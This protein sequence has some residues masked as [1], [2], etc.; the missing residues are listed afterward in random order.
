[1]WEYYQSQRPGQVQVLGPDIFNGTASQL[2]GFRVQ[3]GATYPLLL[4]GGTGAGDEDL[5]SPTTYGQVDNYV[6][7]NKQGVIRYHAY[8]Y[9]P[10]G[11]RYH[12]DELRG[13][14]D[15]LVSN[16]AGADDL[17]PRAYMLNAA[18]NPFRGSTTLELTNPGPS[19]VPAR[20]TAY[21]AAGRR[22]ATL[23]DGLA[24]RGR[25]EVSWDGRSESGAAMG[26]GVYIV[27]AEI[28][29]VRLSRRIV[30]VR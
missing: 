2:D 25:T 29:G 30:R 5:D 16:V 19:E 6:V 23:W 28:G 26:A 10:H 15:S 20:V 27:R 21:D 7:I 8:D 17:I 12:L 22:V 4:N 14:I 9:W 18:P 24:P 1:M 11:N 3:T 13:T